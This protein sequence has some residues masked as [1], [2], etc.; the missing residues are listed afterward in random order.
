VSSERLYLNLACFGRTE[1]NIVLCPS[2]SNN[3]LKL[4]EHLNEIGE[5]MKYIESLRLLDRPL[6]DFNA[7]KHLVFN[8]QNR[9]DQKFKRIWTETQFNTI[10]KFLI[11]HKSC[12]LSVSTKIDVQEKEKNKE[13][14]RVKIQSVPLKIE[15]EP[16]L[17]KPS[18]RYRKNLL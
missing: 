7:I 14:L 5:I 10:E 12:G 9:Y 17:I 1:N 18:I 13:E 15:S 3:I 11:M 6:L 16:V 2:V 4:D 8:I